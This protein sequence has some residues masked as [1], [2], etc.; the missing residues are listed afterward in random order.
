[1]LSTDATFW[2]ANPWLLGRV[3]SDDSSGLSREWQC[4]ARVGMRKDCQWRIKMHVV[5]SNDKYLQ[6]GT[7]DATETAASCWMGCCEP[8]IA[9]SKSSQSCYN[10]K[11]FTTAGHKNPMLKNVVLE[12]C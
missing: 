3:I 2:G 6:L 10:S 11:L 5:Y 8:L 9:C 12:T 1:M 4:S 7:K